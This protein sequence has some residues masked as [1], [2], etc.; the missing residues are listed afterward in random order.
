MTDLPLTL[1]IDERSY[2][3]I[4]RH[5]R[6]RAM[7]L[8]EINPVNAET[9][10]ARLAGGAQMTWPS[11][12]TPRA[13]AG[14]CEAALGRNDQPIGIG[15]QSF[16]DQL[17]ADARTVGIGRVDEGDAQFDYGCSRPCSPRP[18]RPAGTSRWSTDFRQP[19]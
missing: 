11:V 18:A 9:L 6:I 16:G 8:I 12:W 3:V 14:P 10:E 1:E 4:E 17:L 7:Q 19:S 15:R 13:G 2:G 5:A